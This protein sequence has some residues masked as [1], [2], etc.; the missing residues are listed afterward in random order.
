[1]KTKKANIDKASGDNFAEIKKVNPFKKLM[2]DKHRIAD[3]VNNGL[4]L[5][6]LKDIKFI[7]PL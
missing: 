5:S 7:T 2:E 3:A 4:P 6:T 1:M